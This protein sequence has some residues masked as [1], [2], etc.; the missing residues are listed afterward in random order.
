MFINSRESFNKLHH[1]AKELVLDYLLREGADDNILI[2]INYDGV[3]TF[4][5]VNV[6]DTNFEHS[7]YRGIFIKELILE[8]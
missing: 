2:A 6:D 4:N 1:F 8:K 7:V 5:V 3:V